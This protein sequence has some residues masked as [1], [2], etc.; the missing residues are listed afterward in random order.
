MAFGLGDLLQ[1]MQQGVQ[2]I[3]NLTIQI[4]TTFPQAT[5]SS[6]SAPA[7]AGTITFTSSQA[8]GFLLV[9]LSSGATV[10]MPFYPQ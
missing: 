2:A 1:T 3:N 8:T 9:T 4:K 5:T 7:T 10:K 6:T